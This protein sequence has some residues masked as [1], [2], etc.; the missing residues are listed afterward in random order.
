MYREISRNLLLLIDLIKPTGFARGKNRIIRYTYTYDTSV[1]VRKWIFH[2]F[3]MVCMNMYYTYMYV[4]M[5][6]HRWCCPEKSI[7]KISAKLS[8]SI[9]RKLTDR[10]PKL[11]RKFLLL[12]SSLH[13][14]S[15]H[16]F[17]CRGALMND[18]TAFIGYIF[19]I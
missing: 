15:C 16:S 6:I 9:I 3:I 18:L 13:F 11:P 4:H 2:V 7:A 10:S 17:F 1:C 12:T 14:I 5:Y 8:H 19:P